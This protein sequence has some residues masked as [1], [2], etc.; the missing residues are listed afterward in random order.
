MSHVASWSHVATGLNGYISE[1]ILMVFDLLLTS[2]SVTHDYEE[3]NH[4]FIHFRLICE[5][6][7]E[8][9]MTMAFG[10]E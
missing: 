6:Q 9:E 8:I 4:C 5:F 7:I 1:E 3:V 10:L 2:D